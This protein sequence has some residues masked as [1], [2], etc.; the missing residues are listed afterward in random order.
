VLRRDHHRHLGKAPLKSDRT[1]RLVIDIKKEALKRGIAV[2]IV[3]GA[4]VQALLKKFDETAKLNVA[5]SINEARSMA[6]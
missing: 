3:A 4:E 6:A 5:H 1:P 2:K